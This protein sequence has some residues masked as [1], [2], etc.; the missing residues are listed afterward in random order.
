MGC[1]MQR[2]SRIRI[3]AQKIRK[4]LRV[5]LLKFRGARAFRVSGV[6]SKGERKALGTMKKE[7]RLSMEMLSLI[8]IAVWLF[9][10]YKAVAV[11]S[12]LMT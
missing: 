10:L 5:A 7:L 2:I 6:S 3:M 1:P 11:S 9:F 8:C 4:V 12:L